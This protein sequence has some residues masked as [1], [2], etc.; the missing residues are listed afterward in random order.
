MD[1]SDAI[2]M[3]ELSTRPRELVEP[4]VVAAVDGRQSGSS[5]APS[6]ARGISVLRIPG[7]IRSP[8][9]LSSAISMSEL[10]SSS[11]GRETGGVVGGTGGVAGL[12]LVPKAL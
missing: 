7:D 3:R 4:E 9:S 6:P 11:G 10:L 2:E 8:L 12:A 5:V 1:I